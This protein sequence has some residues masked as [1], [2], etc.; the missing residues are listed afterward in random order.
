MFP[1]SGNFPSLVGRSARTEELQ[2]KCRSCPIHR[3][4]KRAQ[5]CRSLM[6]LHTSPPQ[7]H[8][9]WRAQLLSSETWASADRP[10]EGT[11]SGCTASLRARGVHGAVWVCYRSHAVDRRQGRGVGPPEQRHY[12]LAH[13]GVGCQVQQV[14]QTLWV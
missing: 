11:Q 3:R 4:M 13:G 12:Q 2:S 8:T 14:L 6:R 10:G 7:R 1:H 5:H 9:C